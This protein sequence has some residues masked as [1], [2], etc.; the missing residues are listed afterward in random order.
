MRALLHALRRWVTEN[1]PPPVSQYPRLADG[2]LVPIQ[3]LA[4]P[5]IAGVRDPRTIEGP[6]R[7]AGAALP[8]LVP[9]VDDDGNE[10][11]GIRVPDLAVPLATVTVVELPCR[12]GGKPFRALLVARIV[13]SF[14]AHTGRPETYARSS[15][16][17][18]RTVPRPRGLPATNP[19]RSGRSRQRRLPARTRRAGRPGAR[20][21]ALVPSDATDPIGPGR[22]VK[23]VSD[24][25]GLRAAGYGTEFQ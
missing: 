17:G 23:I 8:F 1:A 4:F 3:A 12:P 13:H 11:A 14:P 19:G 7:S 18:R 16:I 24:S 5:R 6:K 2:T 10:R 22:A 9:Q 15:S 25:L 20:R 21:P